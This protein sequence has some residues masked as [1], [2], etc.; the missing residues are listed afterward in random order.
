[1]LKHRLD[2]AYSLYQ[3]NKAS[4]IIISGGFD[5]KYKKYEPII[6]H[7]YLTS[8]GVPKEDIISDLQG[9]N[10]YATLKR[11]K[12]FVGEKSVIFCT[13]ELYSYRAM[14]IA[15]KL[16]LNMNVFCSNPCVY[17]HTIKNYTREALAQ[18]K[19]ILNCTIF[20]PNISTLSNFPFVGGETN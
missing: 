5:E 9:N 2:Y 17:A 11:T 14:Y 12:E 8:L 6:M 18:V 19:A 10:T 7:Q 4:K 20:P 13:Q 1:M 3:A 15:N 16:D